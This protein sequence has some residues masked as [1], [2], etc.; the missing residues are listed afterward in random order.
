MGHGMFS[1]AGFL[2]KEGTPAII[3]HGEGTGRNWLSFA[4]DDLLEKWS[5]PVAVEPVT[6]SGEIPAMRHWD[7]DCWL[8]G[9]TSYAVS[10]GRDPHLMKSS[11]L[12]RWEYLGRLMH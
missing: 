2:T 7:P 5:K 1:G 12:K 11:D 8:H 9:E 6:Q 10:G 4:E 3:Y